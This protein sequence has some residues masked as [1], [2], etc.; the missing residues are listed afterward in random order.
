MHIN[1][2]AELCKALHSASCTAPEVVECRAVDLEIACCHR[3]KI[4][5][6]TCFGILR[7]EYR[8]VVRSLVEIHI[9]AVACYL[10]ELAAELE[11]VI[12]ITR[13]AVA[14]CTF[15]IEDIVHTEVFPLTVSACDICMVVDDHIPESLC[16]QEITR[17]IDLF[18][19]NGLSV[20]NRIPL[21][22]AYELRD[23]G[24][25]VL[26]VEDV[27]SSLEDCLV[28]R[29]LVKIMRGYSVSVLARNEI[30]I[31]H[32]VVH[33]AVLDRK[34]GTLLVCIPLAASVVDPVAERRTELLSRI[35][36]C[37]IIDINDSRDELMH[38]VPRYPR[39][40][41]DI[42]LALL[43]VIELHLDITAVRMTGSP[44]IAGL[45]LGI[46]LTLTHTVNEGLDV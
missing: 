45:T 24:I 22:R 28:E 37:R 18:S 11:H 31:V 5:S 17:C 29:C 39:I 15:G 35:I 10:V 43:N 33:S 14:V 4:C 41:K 1:G 23:R 3:L 30:E 12:G 27:C 38:R 8:I 7:G 16:V 32:T 2:I 9:F 13:L 42:R 26:A 20:E 40:I 19:V 25:G 44:Y 6:H 46:L 34:N 21:E 36:A